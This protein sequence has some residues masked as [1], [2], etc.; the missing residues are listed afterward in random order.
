LIKGRRGIYQKAS[1]VEN[2]EVHSDKYDLVLK[3]TIERLIAASMTDIST[4]TQETFLEEQAKAKK[5]IDTLQQLLDAPVL[6][7]SNISHP[8][9][10]SQTLHNLPICRN[11]IFCNHTAL[12]SR[13]LLRR[14]ME[15]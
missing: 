8:P 13:L 14:M 7:E 6:S 5:Y 9:R 2:K 4:L 12:R 1:C 10:H 3:D 11:T 15:T